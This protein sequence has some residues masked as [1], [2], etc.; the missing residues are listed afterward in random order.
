MKNFKKN[1]ALIVVAETQLDGD[2]KIT[3]ND[4]SAKIVNKHLFGN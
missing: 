3:N 1:L 2:L 4:F